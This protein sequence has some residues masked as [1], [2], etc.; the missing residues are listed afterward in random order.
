[1]ISG[2]QRGHG[3]CKNGRHSGGRRDAGLCAFEG[4]KPLLERG[5]GGIGEARIDVPGGVVA[6]PVR[7]FGGVLNTKL[8]VR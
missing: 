2:L 1:V 3:G 5:H 7:G 6:E 8:E 4:R